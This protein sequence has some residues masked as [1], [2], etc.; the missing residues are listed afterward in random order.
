MV[1]SSQFVG[2]TIGIDCTKVYE[3]DLAL[4]VIYMSFYEG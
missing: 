4:N 2:I 1:K 3:L